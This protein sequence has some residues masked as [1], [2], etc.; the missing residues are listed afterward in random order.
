MLQHRETF[1]CWTRIV[2]RQ[3]PDDMLA[4]RHV[5]G[6][7]HEHS[8]TCSKRS[9][10]SWRQVRCGV[11]LVHICMAGVFLVLGPLVDAQQRA[12]LRHMFVM[13]LDCQTPIIMQEVAPLEEADLVTWLLHHLNWHIIFAT[14]GVHELAMH[15]VLSS[16]Y[17]HVINMSST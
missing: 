17:Q 13:G 8:N 5:V 15:K 10:L 14:H 3:M 12:H 9:A 1:H 7:V 4:V 6:K 11:F 16:N 2:C